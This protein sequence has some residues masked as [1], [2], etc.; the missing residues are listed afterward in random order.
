MTKLALPLAARVANKLTAIASANATRMNVIVSSGTTNA[1][2]ELKK[3][4]PSGSR[5]GTVL[6]PQ[7]AW[8]HIDVLREGAHVHPSQFAALWARRSRTN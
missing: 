3:T 1:R 7:T 2:Q 6:A 5:H 4:V 8:V